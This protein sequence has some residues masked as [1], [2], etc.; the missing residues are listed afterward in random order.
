MQMSKR[1]V[2]PSLAKS[3]DALSA[4][5]HHTPGGVAAD[6]MGLEKGAPEVREVAQGPCPDQGTST[7]RI[8]QAERLLMARYNPPSHAADASDECSGL[9]CGGVAFRLAAE[10]A[11]VEGW[12]RKESLPH[13]MS[14][15]QRDREVIS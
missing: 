7:P 6:F 13:I 14:A 10:A 5:A 11:V 1:E 2:E 8:P 4:F 9:Q 12:I 15:F 3:A